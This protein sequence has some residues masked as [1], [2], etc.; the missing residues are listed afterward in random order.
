MSIIRLQKELSNTETCVSNIFIDEYMPEANGEFVKVY[1]FLLRSMTDGKMECTICGMADRL[2]QTEKDIVRALK[3]WEK[4]GILSLS[5]E[6]ENR[7]NGIILRDLSAPALPSKKT[8]LVSFAAASS[9]VAPEPVESALPQT[10]VVCPEPISPVTGTPTDPVRREYSL[11]EIQQFQKDEAVSELFFIIETYL[12]HPLSSTDTNTILYWYDGL[13]F[14]VELI[15]YLVEYCISKGHSSI[16]YMDKVALCWKEEQITTLEKAK[17]N[18]AMHSQIYYAVMKALGI[19]GRNLVS[20]ENAYIRKWTKEYGFDTELIQEA[21]KRT[22]SATHQPSFEY[23][24]SILTNWHKNQVHTL[25]DIS[26]LDA[27]YTKSRKPAAKEAP[28]RNKFHN[29][30]QRDYDYDELEKMLLTTS[31]Q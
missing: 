10:S 16:R 8:E 18:S 21:C 31:V 30:N 27:A 20:S 17:E 4:T 1:L 22:I 25:A 5:Y 15:E 19:S 12:R 11:A 28:K 3:Y 7:I 26:A 24:D 14:S 6:N 13:K 23:T 9:T 2:Y 29:F